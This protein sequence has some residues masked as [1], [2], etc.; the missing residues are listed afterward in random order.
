[1]RQFYFKMRRLLQNA[2]F[3]TNWDSTGAND[4]PVI[5]RSHLSQLSPII[6]AYVEL[7]WSKLFKNAS[8]SLKHG[9]KL[10]GKLQIR[11]KL[12]RRL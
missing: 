10:C 6:P 7:L 4:K 2:T 9:L 12:A 3:I 5:T 8:C 11:S 1:M